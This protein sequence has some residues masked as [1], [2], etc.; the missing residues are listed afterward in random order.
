MNKI[1]VRFRVPVEIRVHF[2]S[3]LAADTRPRSEKPTLRQLYI[4]TI[5]QGLVGMVELELFDV[6]PAGFYDVFEIEKNLHNR[7]VA[8]KEKAG[9][10]SIEVAC[11]I[12]LKN[13]CKR[14]AETTV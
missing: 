3:I 13:G 5:E 1:L 11:I 4:D 14:K 8:F 10:K 7:I 9:L 2:K 12:L 6:S